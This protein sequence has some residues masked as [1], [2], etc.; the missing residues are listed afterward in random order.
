MRSCI[1]PHAV[2]ILP[3]SRPA[4]LSRT[5]AVIFRQKTQTQFSLISFKLVSKLSQP[6]PFDHFNTSSALWLGTLSRSTPCPSTSSG[7]LRSGYRLRKAASILLKLK[8]SANPNKRSEATSPW[9]KADMCNR[10]VSV[11]EMN[12]CGSMCFM[13]L[14]KFSPVQVALAQAMVEGKP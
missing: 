3:S 13:Y 11:V 12:H 2:T 1:I 14:S 4:Q 5:L 10:A 6:A 7:N 9:I 8:G